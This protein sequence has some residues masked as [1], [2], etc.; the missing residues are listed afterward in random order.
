MQTS[1]SSFEAPRAVCTAIAQAVAFR[2][3]DSAC[4]LI[5][6][7]KAYFSE[8]GTKGWIAPLERLQAIIR[9][10]T[11][12]HGVFAKHGNS[13]LPFVAFSTLPAVTCPGAG[14][15]LQ[16]CYSFRAWRYPSAFVR[17]AANTWLM[18]S[19]EGRKQITS[20]FYDL[21]QHKEFR[22]GFDFR[23]YVDGDYSSIDDVAFWQDLLR[24]APL[25][26]AY[27]YSKSLALL[28][29]YGKANEWAPNYLV[30]ESSGHNADAETLAEFRKLPIV[31]GQFIAVNV[32]HKVG[33]ADHNNPAHK[34]N[35]RKVFAIQENGRKA[36]PCPG[37]C[38]ECTPKGHACGSEA[39]RNVAIVIAVH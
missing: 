12:K 16:F 4:A 9:T 29:A 38:G 36:F 2:S 32:G 6:S 28:N 25:V 27:G 17:Q 11:A 7:A 13:K 22:Y 26:K 3:V 10:N 5:D 21:Y 33:S 18:R 37:K 23:L 24:D 34:A 39:F 1:F 20:A 31:R 19:P 8:R 35:L 30:N 14:E 15:C